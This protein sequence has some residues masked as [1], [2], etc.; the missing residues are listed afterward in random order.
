MQYKEKK[1]KLGI[2]KKIILLICLT[3]LSVMFFGMG[4]DFLWSSQL[5]R[6]TVGNNY[7]ISAKVLA[8]SV[9][10]MLDEKLKEIKNLSTGILWKNFLKEDNARYQAM[11]KQFFKDYLLNMKKVWPQTSEDSPLI[12][13]FLNNEVSFDLKELK[14]RDNSINRILITN[15]TGVLA[16]LSDKTT[17]FYYADKDWWQKSYNQSEG[18]VSIGNIEFDKDTNTWN[19]PFIVPINDENNVVAGICRIDIDIGNFLKVLDDFKIGNT[20]HAGL[21][22][23]NNKVLFHSG[24]KPFSEKFIPDKDMKS[25]LIGGVTWIIT[26]ESHLHKKEKIFISTAKVGHPLLLKKGLEWIVFV[27]QKANEV[28]RPLVVSIYQMAATVCVALMVLMILGFVVGSKAVK[29]IEELRDATAHIIKKDFHYN[30]KVNT[31]DEIEELADSFNQ[32]SAALQISLSEIQEQNEKLLRANQELNIVNSFLNLSLENIPLQQ[33]L[34]LTLELIIS[35]PW[36]ALEAKGSIFLVENNPGVLVMKTQ[37]NLEKS[38]LK[39]CAFLPF[40]KCI[41][42]LA[43][44]K[45]K[46]QFVRNIDETH[47]ITCE[48]MPP[49]GHYCVPI[50]YAEKVIGV[51]NIYVK[52]DHPYNHNEIDFLEAI[53][54]TLA[55]VIQRKETEDS[56]EIAYN[57]LKETQFQLI[58]AAKMEVVGKLASGVAHEVKNPLAVILMGV[59]YLSLNYPFKD[60]NITLIIKDVTEAV[61]RADKIVRGLLDFASVSKLNFVSKN[62]NLILN[63]SLL[64]LKHQFDKN[65]IE[66]IKN[67]DKNIPDVKLDRNRIEQ[68]LINIFINAVNAMPQGGRIIINTFLKKSE[69]IQGAAEVVVE[70]EDT[71]TGIPEGIIDKLFEPFFTTR[72][73]KGGTGL[74]LAI[75]KNILDMHNAK[76]KLENK[77]EN[78]GAKVTITFLVSS[79]P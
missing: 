47:E 36:L 31:N 16:A 43:A 10:Q 35:I 64:L 40:G 76:I 29:P 49:H 63:N 57:K 34:E 77:K 66:V 38:L 62:L 73:D 79:E 72:R 28:F 26:E 48:D 2:R 50:V 11:D 42:G 60:N 30:I 68:V 56:L 13:N 61:E 12:S 71:G 1:I 5:L 7:N 22:D 15:K 41:C 65:H 14:K 21:A 44:L 45:K 8:V 70:I 67:L 23:K 69:S 9:R 53:A 75:V 33:F 58:Q 32:M 4:I 78:N 59:E 46:I 24:I 19:L 37:K 18:K 51:I 54:N 39:E 55:G 20:G 3:T 52:K 74:G 27:E 6:N 25:I 17:N